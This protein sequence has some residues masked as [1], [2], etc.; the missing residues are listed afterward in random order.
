[1]A[2]STREEIERDV[3]AGGESDL[4]RQDLHGLNLTGPD[5]RGVNLLRAEL[6]GADLSEVELGWGSLWTANLTDTLTQWP[7][8]VDPLRV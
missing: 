7:E 3:V 1:M 2:K 4:A 5:I 6:T 8:A